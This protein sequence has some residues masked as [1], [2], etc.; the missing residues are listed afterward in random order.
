QELTKAAARIGEVVDL[1][2]DIAG[3]TNL[4]ALNATIEAARAGEAGKGFA[5]VATE[6]KNL[7]NQT[8]RAT[9]EIS[10]QIAAVQDETRSAVDD[11]QGIRDIIGKIND[12]STAIAAAVERQGV[13]TSEI[14][15]NVQQAATG[16]EEVNANIE[17]VSMA[18][19]E[20][21]S[22][23]RQVMGATE[24]LTQR[25]D[26]LSREVARFLAGVRSSG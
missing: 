14:A 18:A 12:I 1:I 7:A 13:S 9:E 3:Q 10:S 5:V 23:A 8:A 16:T 22:A 2:N 25:A 15:R 19:N 26:D 4:L 20:T 6:V 21:G 11:I 24:S 17:T